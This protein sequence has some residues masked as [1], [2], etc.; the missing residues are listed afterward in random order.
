MRITSA[1]NVG[2]GTTGPGTKLEVYGSITSRPAST[3]D[4]IIISGRA[5]GTSSYAITFT[6]AT[7]SA[8]QTITFPDS[9]GTVAL[10]SDTTYIGTTAV[11]LN[12]ASANL[13]L[14]GI[15]SVN[16]ITVS[17]SSGTF[18]LQGDTQYIGTTAVTLNRASA[19][20]ALTGI[21]SI[22]L[23]GSVSGTIQLAPAPTTS[24]TTYTLPAVA[25]SIDGQVL[26]STTTGVMT[27]GITISRRWWNFIFYNH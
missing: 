22:S 15:S 23:P 6:P 17:G 19:N 9:T 5:G 11:T 13:A 12:R 7:L 8:N 4:A 21:S 16:G 24:N 1:G 26:S 2:I 3:Q 14:T 10:Q 20:L 18:A 27:L 25:P